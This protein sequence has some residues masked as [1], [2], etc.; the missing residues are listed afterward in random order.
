MLTDILRKNGNNYLI[1]DDSFNEN[2]AALP[3]NTQMF[4]TEL[5]TKSK[6]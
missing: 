4:G 5:N 1:F 3:K 6:Q 2:K